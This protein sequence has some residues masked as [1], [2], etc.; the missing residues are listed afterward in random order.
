MSDDPLTPNERALKRHGEVMHALGAIEGKLDGIGATQVRHEQALGL[1]ADR[2]DS[3]EA[4]R[5][6][7]R[8][9]LFIL[10]PA[11]VAAGTTFGEYIK[12]LFGWH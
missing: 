2:V 11:G 4:S 8:S 10:P 12:R 6:R 7:L 1:L 9:L 3:L 5:T